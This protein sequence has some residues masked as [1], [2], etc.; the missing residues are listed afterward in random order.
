MKLK[1]VHFIVLLLILLS[2]LVTFWGA[3]GDR[4]MQMAIGIATSVAYVVW[5]IIYHSL[6]GDMH[7]KVM[8][9][10]LLIGTIAVVILATVLWT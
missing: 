5:G 1:H 2:G 3:A 6:E 7:P 10:Y 4:S 8:I 9:E